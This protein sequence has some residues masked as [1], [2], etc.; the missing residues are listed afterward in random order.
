MKRTKIEFLEAVMQELSE[1]KWSL[2]IEVR[3]YGRQKLADKTKSVIIGASGEQMSVDD[4][5]RKCKKDIGEIEAKIQV[6][7]AEIDDNK[8]K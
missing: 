5:I 2:E 4:F 7:M 8:K 1:R 6:V 3:H